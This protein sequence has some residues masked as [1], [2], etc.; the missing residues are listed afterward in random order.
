MASK[1][2]KEI[3]ISTDGKDLTKNAID[4]G[5]EQVK[6]SGANLHVL[7]VIDTVEF[8]STSTQS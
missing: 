2:L 7:Y 1:L 8:A 5:I 4:R 3:L 6:N